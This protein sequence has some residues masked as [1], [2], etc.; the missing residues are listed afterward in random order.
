MKLVLASGKGGTGKT[1]LA[2]SIATLAAEEGERVTYVDCDV[3]EPNGH[4]LL[5]PDVKRSV[6]V[7]VTV[8][9][10]DDELCTRCGVC[11]ASCQFNAIASLKTGV[12][13][14]PELCHGCGTCSLV[15]PSD[16]IVEAGRSVGK[17]TMGTVGD[18]RFLS[19]TLSVGEASAVPV[20][21]SLKQRIGSDGL[22]VMDAPPGTACP[23]VETMRDADV[24]ILVTEPTPFGLNDLDLAV[25]ASREIGKSPHVVINRCDVGDDRVHQYCRA[26]GLNVIS[27]IPNSIE[28][29]RAYADG[30]VPLKIVPGFRSAIYALYRDV[31]RRAGGL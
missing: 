21:R 11:A 7:E 30:H 25:R 17:L 4:L 20:L 8:P 1:T 28:V 13:V 22:Y 10:V 29:A 15:C 5:R 31:V 2:T 26:N 6:P 12:I 19:G 9:V 14:F 27:E 18:M 24:L 16:A 3:E 23:A